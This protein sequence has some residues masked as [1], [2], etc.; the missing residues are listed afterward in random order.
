MRRLRFHGPKTRP[1]QHQ[2]RHRRH[3]RCRSRRHKGS[4]MRSSVL[5]IEA[6]RS[7]RRRT[8]GSSRA[9][10]LSIA[11]AH[12][13]TSYSRRAKQRLKEEPQYHAPLT[14]TKIQTK[15]GGVT[16][17]HYT[18]PDGTNNHT[19]PAGINNHTTTPGITTTRTPTGINN[20]TNSPFDQQPH[21]LRSADTCVF[22]KSG[23]LTDTS[24]TPDGALP[25]HGSHLLSRGA[26]APHLCVCPS[27]DRF[28]T[29]RARSLVPR[30]PQP[31]TSRHKPHAPLKPPLRKNATHPPPRGTAPRSCALLISGPRERRE[32]ETPRT[33][34]STLSSNS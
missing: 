8:L 33:P 31:S 34:H 6:L 21:K 13:S 15:P 22:N 23:T 1:R 29:W 32:P 12:M 3:R 11:A 4:P 17:R 30:K 9:R 19:K 24:Q 7:R 28:S 25:F 26:T 20:H 27:R 16:L 5:R 10:R 18:N 14:G 2:R